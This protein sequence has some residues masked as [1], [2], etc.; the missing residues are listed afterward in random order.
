MFIQ[1]V[2][3]AFLFC[4]VV[5]SQVS[6]SRTQETTNANQTKPQTQGTNDTKTAYPNLKSQ[7]EEFA[8]AVVKSDFNKVIDLLHPIVIEEAGGREKLLEL[9]TKDMEEMKKSRNE[10]ISAV[11]GDA[12]QIEKVDN[13]LFAVLPL[14]LTL[15]S[16]EGNGTQET[17][18][19]A[20]SNDSGSNWKFVSHLNQ[21]EFNKRFPKVTKLQ[22]PAVKEPVFEKNK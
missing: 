12:K 17:H 10:I 1:R 13:E 16:P 6:C 14:T 21:E 4:G 20:V 22:I 9:V 11:V 5:L 7:A 3:F 8:N 19:V 2:I 15:K 18:M